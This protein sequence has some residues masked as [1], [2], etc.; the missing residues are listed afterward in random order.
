M[1]RLFAAAVMTLVGGW[2][3]ASAPIKA[4]DAAYVG[5]KT[6][7]ECHAE[8]YDNFKNYSKKAHSWDSLQSM[9]SNL[10]PAE[11][12]KCFECHTTGYGKPGGFV[13]FEKTPEL[14][15]V[16]CET[17]HGP[18]KTHAEFGDPAEITRLPDQESCTVCHSEDRIGDFGFVP[19]RYSGAH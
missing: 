11:F 17:C 6:C 8:Q 19:L 12:Q 16:G 18:G 3:L 14:A 10:K 2:F 1:Q 5:S 15:D 9:R 13:S 4:S 7:A